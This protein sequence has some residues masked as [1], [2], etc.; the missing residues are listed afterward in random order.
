M[1]VKTTQQRDII[2]QRVAHA[3]QDGDGVAIKRIAGM[4]HTGMDPILMVDELRSQHEADFMGGFPPHPHRGMQTLTY[5]KL[6]GIVHEDNQ[7]NRGEIRGGGA[8][9]M[10]AGRGIIHSEMPTQDSA[11][12][13][14]FQLWINLP[15]GEKMSLPRYR[16]IP[17]DELAIHVG[18]DYQ[19][20]AISGSWEW[21]ADKPQANQLA[22][23]SVRGPLVELEDRAAIADLSLAPDAHLSLLTENEDSV[24]AYIYEGSIVSGGVEN[25]PQTL[26]I[27]GQG[28]EWLLKAGASGASVLVMRGQ[29]L[30]EPV[31]HYGPFVMNTS[32][33]IEEAIRAYQAGE[34]AQ[35]A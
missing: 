16:D 3:S 5:M 23:L 4:T 20:T 11:G 30:G 22:P 12:L 21:A 13:H 8:Q 9:W 7:G 1:I 25:G 28:N 24:L 34:F 6:G 26:L 33:E 19:L 31:A 14:G 18:S 10:S 32:D 15:R 27:T 35:I 29:P 2:E 17:A